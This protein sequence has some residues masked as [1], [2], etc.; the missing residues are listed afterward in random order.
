MT[1]LKSPQTHLTNKKRSVA[2][3]AKRRTQFSFSTARISSSF[4]VVVPSKSELN[5]SILLNSPEKTWVEGFL[6]VRVRHVSAPC[7]IR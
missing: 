2:A 1:M 4:E 7:F 5:H 6:K 3:V